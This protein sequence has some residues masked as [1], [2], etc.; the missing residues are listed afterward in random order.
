MSYFSLR[1][2]F[3]IILISFLLSL[4]NL[5]CK[6]E[7]TPPMELPE[8]YQQDISWPSLADSPWPMFHH[9]PQST[10]RS[11]YDITLNGVIAGTIE[12]NNLQ[13]SIIVSK[14]STIFFALSGG[15]GI[16]KAF[17]NS[18]QEWEYIFNNNTDI[19]L[20][21]LIDKN[22]NIY[23]GTAQS[24]KIYSFNKTGNKNWEFSTGHRIW[25]TSLNIDKEGNLYF[26]DNSQT[27]YCIS[28]NGNLNWSFTD[29]RMSS[30]TPSSVSFSPD[31]KNIYI[32]GCN[33]VSLLSFDITEKKVDW[34][35]G[36][37]IITEHRWLIQMGTFI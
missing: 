19:F 22:G 6:D 8:G 20:S 3:S 17:K 32:P 14:D 18:K 12:A 25:Q 27:L 34:S 35:F 5:S 24:G 31:G 13:S 16:L 9:D 37:K 23:V 4:F 28:S 36:E 33:G 10:G 2:T 7:G 26:I 1:K 21:P 30:G 11:K 15:G 29:S